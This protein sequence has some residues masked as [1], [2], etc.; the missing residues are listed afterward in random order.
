MPLAQKIK[1]FFIVDGEDEQT[2]KDTDPNREEGTGVPPA[3]S[4]VDMS[5]AKVSDGDVSKMVGHLSNVLAEN[6]MEGF[7][8]F[9]FRGAVQELVKGGTPE[10][11]AMKSVFTTAK[12]MGCT[13]QTLLSSIQFY[14]TKLADEKTSFG[15]ELKTK[16]KSDVS[17]A[18]AR[19][20][21]I[22]G[23]LAALS[24]EKEKL[25][26]SATA[27]KTKL[28][29]VEFAFGEAYGLVTKKIKDDEAKINTLLG[30]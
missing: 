25:E 2:K 5:N 9:E 14:L 30:D 29:N 23:Q 22:E 1:G 19:I 10:D 21:E 6:N 17:D 13:K 24:K 20:K 8:Y 15:N 4:S 26:K 12:T 7:D 18:E 28:N 16:K 3:V 11:S 27:N